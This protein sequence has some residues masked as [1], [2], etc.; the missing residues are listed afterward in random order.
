MK[1]DKA[2]VRRLAKEWLAETKR[3]RSQ[4]VCDCGCGA[5]VS[6]KVRFRPGH[7]AKLLRLYA[8]RINAILNG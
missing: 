4:V 2:A 1:V 3:L 7:D 8:E 6:G 5:I